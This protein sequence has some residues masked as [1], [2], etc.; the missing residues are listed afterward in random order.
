MGIDDRA[1][2]ESGFSR[3]IAWGRSTLE[4][5]RQER[6]QRTSRFSIQRLNLSRFS[7][8]VIRR[9]SNHRRPGDMGAPALNRSAGRFLP[10]RSLACP[11]S[12]WVSKSSSAVPLSVLFFQY[13]RRKPV[14]SAS[15]PQRSNTG[16]S[17][18]GSDPIFYF[19]FPSKSM[20]DRIVCRL[21][22]LKELPPGWAVLIRSFLSVRIHHRHVGA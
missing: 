8:G 16:L 4:S 19:Q 20:A 21:L 2:T 10:A 11:D 15:G 1:G 22:V 18:W 6:L 7:R 9:S 3:S 12:F 5:C 13:D 14:E 17:M